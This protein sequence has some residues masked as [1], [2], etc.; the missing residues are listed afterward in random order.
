MFKRE[1]NYP[2]FVIGLDI[3]GTKIAGAIL[4][5][6]SIGQAPEI[7]YKDKVAAKAK[8]GCA[9]FSANINNFALALKNKATEIDP[10]IPVVAA[11]MGCAGRINK[12]SGD[13][14]TATD[15]FPGFAG[16]KLCKNVSN[17]IGLPAFALNDVQ[18]H[19]LGEAR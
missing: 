5:Y 12:I 4:K 9:V 6:T 16:Y 18:S 3:G 8:E 15:N 7:V 10:L 13:V 11:G 14:I 19:T 17:T 2:F 1:E